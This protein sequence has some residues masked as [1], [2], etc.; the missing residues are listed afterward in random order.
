MASPL[1]VMPAMGDQKEVRPCGLLQLEFELLQREVEF[2]IFDKVSEGF[3]AHGDLS[4]EEVASAVGWAAE[5]CCAF[6][7]RTFEASEEL[8]WRVE[9][10]RPP[11]VEE[12]E[13][14]VV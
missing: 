2:V 12:E 6:L 3:L 7:H 10:R 1:L 14:D 9:L 13:L 8:E 5:A 11:E 4:R